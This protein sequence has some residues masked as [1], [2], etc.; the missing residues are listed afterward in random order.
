MIEQARAGWSDEPYVV[1][2]ARGFRWLRFSPELER[3]FREEYSLQHSYCTTTRRVC[4][5]FSTC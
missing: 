4:C 5:G 3:E 2:R 1:Q